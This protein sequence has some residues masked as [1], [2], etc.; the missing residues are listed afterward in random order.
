MYCSTNILS[1]GTY[2]MQDMGQPRF[3]VLFSNLDKE[4]LYYIVHHKLHSGDETFL[5]ST[6]Y[7]Q[8][9]LL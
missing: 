8:W 7:N 1:Q 4:G 5:Y 3:E 9:G 6:N 2:D